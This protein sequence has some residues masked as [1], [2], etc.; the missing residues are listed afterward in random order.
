MG[1]KIGQFVWHELMTT[2]VAAAKTFYGQLLGWDVENSPH[3]AYS[4]WKA[5]G[6]IVAGLMAMPPEVK[7]MGVPPHWMGYVQVEDV[8]AV[9]RKVRELGGTVH[10]SG[11]DVPGVGRFAVLAD[12]QGA[13]F[14]VLEAAE[15]AQ[16]PC[17]KD[18]FGWADL[19]TTDWQ[20]AWKFYEAIFGWKHTRAMEMGPELGTYFMFGLDGEKSMGGM[21]NASKQAGAPA[22][23]VHY[24]E[25]ADCDATTKRVPELGGKVHYGPADIPGGGRMSH[26]RDPQGAEFALYSM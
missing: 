2:D 10:V 9:V 5:S 14:S 1:G 18:L 24:I 22:Y 25:V 4:L 19:S 6:E 17:G 15:G 26:C 13:A 8:D 16:S 3:M 7:A 21:S 11:K 12:P 20:A 23:W